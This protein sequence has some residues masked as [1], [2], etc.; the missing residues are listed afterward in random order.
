MLLAA[1]H[2]PKLTA[3][4]TVN[5]ES[6]LL[7]AAEADAATARGE[8][9]GPLHGIPFTAK[10]VFDTAGARS[11]RGSSLFATR[12]PDKDATAVA[13]LKDAGAIL[14][15]KTNCERSQLGPRDRCHDS[16][17][18]RCCEQARNLRWRI[19]LPMISSVAPSIPTT[20]PARVEVQAAAKPPQ[21]PPVSRHSESVSCT[22]VASLSNLLFTR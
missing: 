15:G 2:N 16:D 17:G 10:D 9:W 18:R 7:R 21:S 1:V 13:R 20:R 8:S 12:V 3:V 6:A 4:V 14:L 5:A 11:T 22:V 19:R